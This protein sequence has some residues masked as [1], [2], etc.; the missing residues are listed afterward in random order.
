M[1][2]ESAAAVD[3]G[4]AFNHQAGD[5]HFAKE[6]DDGGH[7]GMAVRGCRG[8]LLHANAELQQLLFLFLFGERA[9]HQNI[10][11]RGLGYA[12]LE[13]QAQT[14]IE[15]HAQERAAARTAA[16]VS[17][18][19]IVGNHGANADQ[20]RVMLMTKFLHVS[21]CRFTRDPGGDESCSTAVGIGRLFWRRRDF[22]VERHRGL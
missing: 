22:A 18:Q 19:R 4:A 6:T 20:N 10:V 1:P 15:D 2:A 21:A 11:L 16:A 7:V 8:Q 17:K 13:G 12:G 14:R 3:H 9:K 5:L